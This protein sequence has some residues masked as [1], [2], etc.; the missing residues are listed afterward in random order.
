MPPQLRV[1]S[2]Q[3]LAGRGAVRLC[4][5]LSCPHGLR[6]GGVN[7]AYHD[8]MATH[9]IN[10]S[11]SPF[12]KCKPNVNSLYVS[13]NRRFLGHTLTYYDICYV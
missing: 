8:E 7:A 10:R 12:C 3:L 4:V 2:T 13:L 9:T 1:V 5:E 6:D 11:P